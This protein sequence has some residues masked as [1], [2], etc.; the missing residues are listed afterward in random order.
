VVKRLWLVRHG[1]TDWTEE[2]RLTGWH[3]VPLNDRG[4]EQ[5]RVL[6]GRLPPVPP[7]RCWTSD[8]SRARESANLALG[9]ARADRRLRELDFGEIEGARWDAIPPPA[10]EALLRFDGF[11]A[12]GGESVHDLRARVSGFLS[13]LAEGDHVLFTHGGVVRLLLGSRRRLDRVPPGG[14]R[15]LEWG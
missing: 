1:A 2:G 11:R 12:P 8:L 5:A 10:R 7:V 3:D 6:A 9:A 4:R 15:V 13:G 14:L